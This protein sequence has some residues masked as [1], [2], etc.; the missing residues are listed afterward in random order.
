[1]TLNYFWIW[2]KFPVVFNMGLKESYNNWREKLKKE[3]PDKLKD[4]ENKKKRKWRLKK[5]KKQKAQEVREMEH[6]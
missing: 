5:K 2:I 6:L 3:N 4:I 1:M